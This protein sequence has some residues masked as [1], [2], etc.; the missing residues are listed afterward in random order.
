MDRGTQKTAP[1]YFEY[2]EAFRELIGVIVRI[3]AL[4]PIGLVVAAFSTVH[5]LGWF[6]VPIV[7]VAFAAF[8]VIFSVFS[9]AWYRVAK[10]TKRPALLA[11]MVVCALLAV[12][13]RTD[14]IVGIRYGSVDGEWSDTY[15]PPRSPFWLK[16]TPDQLLPGAKA[17]DHRFLYPAKDA[18]WV[19]EASLEVNWLWMSAR[20]LGYMI[21]P[22]AGI[23]RI[24][25]LASRSGQ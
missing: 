24:L 18:T 13:F 5:S 9:F 12:S 4:L 23:S 2:V 21:I 14:W 8:L 15:T 3:G 16:P 7:G 20:V 19:G 25:R 6:K 22:F 1:G 17:W 10:K 11:A